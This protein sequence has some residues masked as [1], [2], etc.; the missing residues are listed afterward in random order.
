MTPHAIGTTERH[1]STRRTVGGRVWLRGVG[2]RGDVSGPCS[3]VVSVDG[4]SRSAYGSRPTPSSNGRPLNT[5]KR[6]A[7]LEPADG[8]VRL[9][10]K[11]LFTYRSE[12]EGE[13]GGPEVLAAWQAFFEG[14]GS[15]VLDVGNPIFAREAVGECSSEKTVLGGY[16]IVEADS[17]EDAVQLA[18]NC[19][20][21]EHYR[22]GVEVGEI[23]Q[24]NVESVTTSVA[25]H[26]IATGIA[27]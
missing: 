22:G 2:P 4:C 11:F 8:R 6:N 3:A 7:G 25:D 1:T 12:A 20:A 19:P 14:L 16:S 13:P 9:M 17:L 26:T 24:L 18:G 15:S 23:T 21:I 10:P 27:D 5:Q